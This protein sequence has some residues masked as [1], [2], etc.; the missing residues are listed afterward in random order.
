MNSADS[1]R[2]VVI[3]AL[4]VVGIYAYRRLTETVS[5]QG[6]SVKGA[7]GLAN[8]LPV[9]AFVTAWGFTFFVI[10]LMA[11]FNPALG[12]AFALLVMTTDLLT[13]APALFSKTS[14]LSGQS[15]Q[16]TPTKKGT[17]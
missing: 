9:S 12:G 10:A 5:T 7:L 8:P 13:N 16:Q 14:R 2:W 3:A 17:A 1:D 4:V 11:A 6:I 15:G